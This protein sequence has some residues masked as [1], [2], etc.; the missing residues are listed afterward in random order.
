MGFW[1]SLW[2]CVSKAFAPIATAFS[3]VLQ[4]SPLMQKLVPILAVVI[5]PP[6]DALA[7]IALEVVSA[8]MGKPENPEELGWQ[9]NK[10]EKGLEDFDSFE[11]Y[12]EYLDREYP[13][14]R[15]AF[16]AQTDEQKSACRYAGIAGAMSELSETDGFDPKLTPA[17]LGV[18]AGAASR[19]GWSRD[20]M[21]SF[22]EG[23]TTSFGGSG[24]LFNHVGDFAKGDLGATEAGRV[25]EGIKDGVK[26]A[27]VA[28]APSAVADALRDSA[29]EGFEITTEEK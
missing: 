7:V 4:N 8:S 2:S 20:E 21:R 29:V 25:S 26:A 6:L 17:A 13:F 27:G 23:M 1:S 28:D 11:D 19:L 18:V 9:M 16:D 3:S 5:P 14:D 24:E 15:D 10:A 22:M 12:R